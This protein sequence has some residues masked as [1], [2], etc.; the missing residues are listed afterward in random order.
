MALQCEALGGI[1]SKDQPNEI[2]ADGLQRGWMNFILF[3]WL[4]DVAGIGTMSI[5]LSS[6]QEVHSHACAF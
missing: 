2:S 6:E 5:H 3:H 4:L 1:C